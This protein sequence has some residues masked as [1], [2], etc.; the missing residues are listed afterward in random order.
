MLA[1]EEGLINAGNTFHIGARGPT[2]MGGVFEFTRGQGYELIPDVDM[3]RE[4]LLATMAHTSKRLA[5][6]VMLEGMMLVARRPP[7]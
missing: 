2:F 7:A 3:R 6:C 4:G 5:G 1:A